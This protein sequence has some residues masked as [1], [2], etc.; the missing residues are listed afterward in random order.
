MIASGAN[1]KRARLIARATTKEKANITPSRAL[2]AREGF[3][4]FCGSS[5]KASAAE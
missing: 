3:L 4:A 5:S 1:L 2:R